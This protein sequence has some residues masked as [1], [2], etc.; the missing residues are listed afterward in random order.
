MMYRVR[1]VSG[2]RRGLGD[3]ASDCAGYSFMQWLVSPPCWAYSPSTW[4]ALNLQYPSPPAPAPPG[5]P[6][7]G[8]VQSPG[9]LAPSSGASAQQAISSAIDQGVTNT[10]SQNQSFFGGMTVNDTC[11]PTIEDCPTGGLSTT[12]LIAIG[13]VVGVGALILTSQSGRR[14]R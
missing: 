6:T 4:N 12:T 13:L 1:G 10:Q 14:R 11:D 3:L 8:T 5:V 9:T 7:I 2:I